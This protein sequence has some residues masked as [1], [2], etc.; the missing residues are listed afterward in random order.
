MYQLVPVI[1]SLVSTMLIWWQHTPIYFDNNN[2][3]N[4]SILRSSSCKTFS[5]SIGKNIVERE[6]ENANA[7]L[8]SVLFFLMLY[9]YNINCIFIESAFFQDI[10]KLL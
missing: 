3:I 5:L 1:T 2:N 4:K 9:Y 7:C 6:Q 10:R 8:L